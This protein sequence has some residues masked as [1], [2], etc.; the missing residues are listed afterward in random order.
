MVSCTDYTMGFCGTF[1]RALRARSYRK[2][3][4]ANA[5]FSL[6]F[7][8]VERDSVRRTTT[9]P[10]EQAKGGSPALKVASASGYV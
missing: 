9:N 5:A 10:I 7:S 8:K 3:L 2:E 6:C 1:V 4:I